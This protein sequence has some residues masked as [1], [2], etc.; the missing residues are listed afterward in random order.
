MDGNWP[1]S[2]KITSFWDVFWALGFSRKSAQAQGSPLV[3][4]P[5]ALR[6]YRSREGAV[7][8]SPG[9]FLEPYVRFW[10]FWLEGSDFRTAIRGKV[11]VA[12]SRF[13]ENRLPELGGFNFLCLV[14]LNKS[15]PG[16]FKAFQGVPGR[17]WAFQGVPGVTGGAAL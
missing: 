13:R 14:V 6:P 2:T 15:V 11:D 16:R 4:G 9:F 17:A 12:Y 1:G 3:G 7:W 8:G 5:L 10:A